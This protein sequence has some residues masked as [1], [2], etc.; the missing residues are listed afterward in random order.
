MQNRKEIEI[1]RCTK[2]TSARTD[3]SNA[4]LIIVDVP[5]RRLLR[6]TGY[7]YWVAWVTW[8]W[9]IST[10]LAVSYYTYMSLGIFKDSCLS[11]SVQLNTIMWN[12]NTVHLL[13][14]SS[15][16]K[17]YFSC[18]SCCVHILLKLKIFKILIQECGEYI[19]DNFIW[20][21]LRDQS[22]RCL[23]TDWTKSILFSVGVEVIFLCHWVQIGLKPTY[24]HK[25][26]LK[27]SPFRESRATRVWNWSPISVQCRG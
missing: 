15:D 12:H 7:N 8:C 9:E 16:T 18:W 27:G 19:R 6:P 20:T 17:Q 24:S 2:G 5:V 21:I 1:F 10:E 14:I 13:L 23:V 22:L 25:Q 26:L 11:L 4:L 3:R